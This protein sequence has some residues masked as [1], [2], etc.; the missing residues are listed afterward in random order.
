[1]STIKRIPRHNAPPIYQDTRDDTQYKWIAGGFG[2]PADRPGALI[3]VGVAL[4]PDVLTRVFRIRVL[5]VHEEDN[6]T[7]L[8]RQAL[9]MRDDYHAGEWYGNQKS[10]LMQF[11]HAENERLTMLSQP[12]F[13]LIEPHGF[14][15]IRPFLFYA[16]AVKNALQK[17]VL[18]LGGFLEMIDDRLK[19]L[20]DE[21]L[22]KVKVI[23]HPMISALGYVVASLQAL[24]PWEYEERK[25]QVQRMVLDDTRGFGGF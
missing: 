16:S 3:V 7:E 13:A 11:V 17:D 12:Y 4:F 23:T 8:V 14:R 18:H 24:R 20:S 22:E 9:R 6:V 2:W 19:E 10:P 21:G 25:V 15:D 1:M 5:A